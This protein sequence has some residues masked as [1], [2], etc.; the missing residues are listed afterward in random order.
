MGISDNFGIAFAK[1]Q[2]GAGLSLPLGGNVFISVADKDKPSIIPIAKE[3]QSLGFKIIATS[4]T[5]SVLKK[6]GIKV[7]AVKKIAEGRPHVEDYIKN[8]EIQLILNTPIGKG[9]KFDE[10]RIRREATIRQIPIITT[11]PG[12][13]AAVDGIKAMKTGKLQVK[14]LQEYHQP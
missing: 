1:A 7:K 12:A 5:A 10:Y 11:I 9:P 3:L 4:G 6:N 2:M 8:G 13:R 14:P